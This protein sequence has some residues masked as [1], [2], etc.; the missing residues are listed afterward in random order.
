M[1]ED[2][3]PT[4]PALSN[5]LSLDPAPP[6]QSVESSKVWVEKSEAAPRLWPAFAVAAVGTFAGIFLLRKVLSV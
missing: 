2:F 4:T 5:L 1:A 3:S 6:E